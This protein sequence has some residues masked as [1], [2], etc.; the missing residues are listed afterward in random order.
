MW[1]ILVMYLQ[2]KKIIKKATLAQREGTWAPKA[3]LERAF[4]SVC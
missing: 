2:K 3:P 4:Y 1:D